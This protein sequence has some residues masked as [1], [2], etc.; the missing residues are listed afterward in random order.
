MYCWCPFGQKTKEWSCG[1]KLSRHSH[2]PSERTRPFLLLV[3]KAS[4]EKWGGSAVLILWSWENKELENTLPAPGSQ[5]SKDQEVCGSSVSLIHTP[6]NETNTTRLI[7]MS[8]LSKRPGPYAHL[9]S[10][11][12]VG[13]AL[14]GNTDRCVPGAAGS[15]SPLPGG[16][17]VLRLS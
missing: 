9:G 13:L 1:F 5:A 3:S 7:S 15:S 14:G 12:L 11:S 4:T 8:W 10:I 16:S 17:R 2:P 6:R